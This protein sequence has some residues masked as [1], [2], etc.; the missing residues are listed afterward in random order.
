[1]YNKYRLHSLD[2]KSLFTNVY[3]HYFEEKLF[4]IYKVSL[5]FLYVADTFVLILSNTDPSSLL[6]LVSKI[7][8]FIHFRI[9]A[10]NNDSFPFLYVLYSKHKNWFS[11]IIFRKSFAIFLSL[12]VLSNHSPH[13]K[14]TTL[15]TNFFLFYTFS[16][17]HLI[18]PMNLIT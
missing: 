3:M 12:N 14:M 6:S 5:W 9:K 2:T 15:Y 4:S 16:V 8:P 1:M 18:F 7:D 10:E 11:K 13:D 17:T